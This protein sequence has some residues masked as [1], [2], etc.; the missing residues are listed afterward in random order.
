MAVLLI[1]HNL[2]IVGDLADQLAVMYAGQIV[3]S[4]PTREVLQNPLH[5]YTQALIESVPRLGAESERLH[6]IPGT[7]P[8][9]SAL[10][11]GCRFH[12]RC[13]IVQPEC[14]KSSVNLSKLAAGRQV[15][16]PYAK[17]PSAESTG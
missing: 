15:R 14:S 12:P 3:E 10:P 9:L 16:C 13:P 17:A 2:G 4:G 6:A 11:S 7:V 5:P 1:T 8:Q